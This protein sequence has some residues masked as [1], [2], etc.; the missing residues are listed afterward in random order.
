MSIDS[1]TALIGVTIVE[2]AS[3]DCTR[4]IPFIL[5]TNENK[6]SNV[7]PIHVCV[8]NKSIRPPKATGVML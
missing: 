6:E 3:I 5:K 7:L 2:K 8:R 1:K 4:M